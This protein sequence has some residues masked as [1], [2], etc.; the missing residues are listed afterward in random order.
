MKILIPL[1]IVIES[2]EVAVVGEYTTSE[3]PELDDHFIVLVTRS[4]GI[5][6]V[7]IN[8]ETSKVAADIEASLG[9]PLTLGLCNRTDTASRIIFPRSLLDQPLFLFREK[10]VERPGALRGFISRFQK[11]DVEMVLSPEAKTCITLGRD[12][13]SGIEHG[14]FDIK[15]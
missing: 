15:R 8:N 13:T 5:T 12:G 9:I 2:D 10:V 14:S 11:Q 7:P 3:G 4:G 1:G 6:S